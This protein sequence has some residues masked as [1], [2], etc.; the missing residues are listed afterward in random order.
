LIASKTA[1][2]TIEA[3]DSRPQMCHVISAWR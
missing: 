1:S 3:V 2:Y